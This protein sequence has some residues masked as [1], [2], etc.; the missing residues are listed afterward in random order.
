MILQKGDVVRLKSG[1]PPL[2]V[3]ELVPAVEARAATFG[4]DGTEENKT[5]ELTP[6]IPA[7][8]AQAQC[9]WFT[10]EGEV[11]AGHFAM[12]LLVGPLVQTPYG[13]WVLPET[14]V[15]SVTNPGAA[16]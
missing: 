11:R 7:V 14:S 6:A 5:V 12:W 15:T 4:S 3:F 10:D 9:V 1:G 2:T 16:T 13:E 8:N